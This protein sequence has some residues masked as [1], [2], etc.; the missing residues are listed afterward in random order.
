M[1]ITFG[2]NGLLELLPIFITEPPAG[3]AK[4]I[5]SSVSADVILSVIVLVVVIVLPIIFPAEE[6]EKLLQ[7]GA[8]TLK[9]RA[10]LQQMEVRIG[11]L[12][13]EIARTRRI[14]S[15]KPG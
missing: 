4:F 14:L 5:L 3:S 1:Y 8:K 9:E 7:K 12:G 15:G 6:T 10:R 13:R 11:E 2:E